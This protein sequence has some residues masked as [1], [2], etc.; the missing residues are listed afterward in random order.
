MRV[1]TIKTHGIDGHRH[2]ELLLVVDAYHLL[3]PLAGF[4]QRW[5][6]HGR[7]NG[8][9]GDDNQQLY[10]CETHYLFP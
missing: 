9:D 8:N 10:Q 2:S 7:Q 6:K 4:L 3:R 1:E 5:E